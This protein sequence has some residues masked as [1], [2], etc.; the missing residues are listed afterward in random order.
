M[1]SENRSCRLGEQVRSIKA[2]YSLAPSCPTAISPMCRTKSVDVDEILPRLHAVARDDQVCFETRA[3]RRSVRQVR[4]LALQLGRAAEVAEI[5]RGECSVG[6]HRG[7]LI[8]IGTCDEFR[9][10]LEQRDRLHDGAC[11]S[12]CPAPPR[13]CWASGTLERFDRLVPCAFGERHSRRPRVPPPL[14]H[15]PPARAGRHSVP[16]R[17]TGPPRGRRL[18][19]PPRRSSPASRDRRPSPAPPPPPRPAPGL[20]P[21]DARRGGGSALSDASA[22]ARCA[23]RLSAGAAS[24]VARPSDRRVPEH[25]PVP[26]RRTSRAAWAASSASSGMSSAENAEAIDADP[27]RQRRLPRAH[28]APVPA[29]LLSVAGTRRLSPRRRSSV[30]ATAAIP[31]SARRSAAPRREKASGL[32]PAE[33]G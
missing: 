3:R 27:T 6:E 5:V 7:G 17:R 16:D 20:L 24:S 31:A 26:S 12:R 28:G 23:D 4:P 19:W 14:R 9:L 25:D 21:P 2:P 33:L 11:A 8:R 32:P 29:V 10:A 30:A 22:S 18:G 13:T 1:A 15:T